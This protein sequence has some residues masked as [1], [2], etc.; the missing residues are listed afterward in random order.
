[1]ATTYHVWFATKRRAWLLQED[2]GQAAKEDLR[3]VAREKGISLLECETAVDHVHLLL[4]LGENESLPKVMNLLKGV[5]SYRLH[6]MFPE[7]KLDSGLDRF[8][9]RGYDFR[10]VAPGS[11]ATRRRY[12]RTQ[13]ERLDSF[14]ER[15]TMPRPSGRGAGNNPRV[16]GAQ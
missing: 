6:S 13:K 14:E 12:V 3:Q 7:L 4:R 9:Q 10:I 5:S 16:S 15:P 1:M 8:W 11:L 2:V